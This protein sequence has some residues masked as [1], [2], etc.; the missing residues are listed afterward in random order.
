M[1]P[2]SAHQ[3]EKPLVL[4]I[5]DNITQ[6]DLYAM[7]LEPHFETLVATRAESGYTLALQAVPQVIVIDALL[8]DGDGLEVARRLQQHAA[9]ARVPII[10][11]TG[12]E[13]AYAR[14]QRDR[15]ELTGVLLKPCR[16]DKL[17]A[18]IHAAI[19]RARLA[20]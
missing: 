4:L 15:S 8:P 5:D 19:E 13:S 17:L 2:A 12:D 14:A 18:A 9:T 6:L 7:V 16:G 11:L 3:F 1:F 20:L 10:V